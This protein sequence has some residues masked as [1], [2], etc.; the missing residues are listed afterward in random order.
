MTDSKPFPF[1]L[2]GKS[3]EPHQ[4]LHRMIIR[5][6]FD[7]WL[8]VVDIATQMGDYP[9]AMCSDADQHMKRMIG[10]SMTKGWRQA[11]EDNL[12]KV[13]GC[14]HMRELLYNMAT[15]AFQT[16]APLSIE[17]TKALMDKGLLNKAPPHLG[18]CHTFDLGSEVVREVFPMFYQ[19]RQA[20]QGK[21]QGSQRTGQAMANTDINP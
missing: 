14:T 3:L 1:A 10:C 8:T 20:Q 2:P 5:V 6:T 11:I 21:E 4:A 9:Y 7:E 17:R 16:L 18:Q 12:G 15:V 13:Q 19:P